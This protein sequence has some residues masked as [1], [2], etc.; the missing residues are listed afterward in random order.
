MYCCCVVG[1]WRRT[2]RHTSRVGLYVCGVAIVLFFGQLGRLN[3]GVF[4]I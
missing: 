2:P 4:D 1:V 3:S